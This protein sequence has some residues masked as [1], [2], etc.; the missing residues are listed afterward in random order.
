[1]SWP[2]SEL[3]LSGPA[4]PREIRHAYAERL[5]E[6]HP[7]ED[8]EGFQ[9]L[10]AAYE[11]ARRAAKQQRHSPFSP[12]APSNSEKTHSWEN[13]VD[14]EES[15]AP[16]DPPSKTE[17]QHQDWDYAELFEKAE[18]Q[19]TET[20]DPSA[21]EAE[22]Q[23]DD[24]DFDELIETSTPK[25]SPEPKERK[26]DW[27]YAKLFEE[28]EQ[29]DI[30]ARE[31][32]YAAQ[33]SSGDAQAVMAA[34]QIVHMLFIER[35]PLS[36]WMRFLYGGAF[37]RVKGDPLFL[38][39]LSA[40]FEENPTLDQGIKNAFLTA[41]GLDPLH[42]PKPYRALYHV[43]TDRTQTPYAVKQQKQKRRIWA[44]WFTLWIPLVLLFIFK[45]VPEARLERENTQLAQQI[46]Q[47][48]G[49]AV[50]IMDK[51]DDRE[52][53]RFTPL[54]EPGLYFLVW[55]DGERD[56]ESGKLGYGTNFG[57]AIVNS[58]LERFAEK[59]EYTLHSVADGYDSSAKASYFGVM[60]SKYYLNLPLSGAGDGII[61]LG[62]LLEELQKES[63]FEFA[64]P[65]FELYL[66]FRD[67]SYYK[68]DWP[69]EPFEAEKVREYYDTVVPGKLA[70]YFIQES[71]LGEADFGTAD[72]VLKDL[73]TVRYRDKPF[74]LIGGA[75]SETSPVSYLYL[76]GNSSIKSIKAE[77]FDEIMSERFLP[78]GDRFESK[79][80]AIPRA[81]QFYQL[82]E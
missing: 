76:Y 12:Q 63:W 48:F 36:D 18:Q 8:P 42:I 54:D 67:T 6:T 29:Q 35:R 53:K 70:M 13:T 9:R 44:L 38:S 7:E 57:N 75:K 77:D 1:M 30:A 81:L 62:A 52:K 66:A 27:D 5:K 61:A 37:F 31:K 2:W 71:G 49:R 45:F 56:L 22:K 60:P 50:E 20:Q 26:Q 74:Y 59:W 40:F 46:E 25:S 16:P 68:C 3:G 24:W 65:S 11:A 21:Q 78:I 33:K 39:E 82:S 19:H 23:P 80:E 10:H 14:F 51:H 47:D 64:P 15:T 73:G 32:R 34:M 28:A 58:K 4:S 79:S 55:Q 17:E 69:K 41:Y 43:L 72:Y